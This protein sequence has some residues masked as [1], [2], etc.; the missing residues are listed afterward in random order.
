MTTTVYVMMMLM[1]HGLGSKMTNGF[2]KNRSMMPNDE[3]GDDLAVANDDD[4]VDN[5]D[6]DGLVLMKS[7]IMTTMR[8]MIMVAMKMVMAMTT[9]KMGMRWQW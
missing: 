5:Y 1:N 6:D 2:N 8:M 3:A 9:V 4:D 7:M